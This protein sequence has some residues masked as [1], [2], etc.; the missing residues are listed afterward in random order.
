[1]SK[2]HDFDPLDALIQCQRLSQTSFNNTQE[3][4]RSHNHLDK[5][6]SE[7]LQQHNNL[8][9]LLMRTRKELQKLQRELNEIKQDKNGETGP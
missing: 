9:D 5:L 2:F 6:L 1:M 8:V 7:L 3:L 4:A